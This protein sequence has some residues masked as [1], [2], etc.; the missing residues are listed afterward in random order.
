MN[1]YIFKKIECLKWLIQPLLFLLC[2]VSLEA[3]EEI[4]QCRDFAEAR[5]KAK[6]FSNLTSSSTNLETVPAKIL[7]SSKLQA[8]QIVGIKS[9]QGL[10]RTDYDPVKGPHFNAKSGGKKAAFCYPG[11]EQSHLSAV[12]NL[13]YGLKTTYGLGTH[14]STQST[15][16]GKTVLSRL[17]SMENINVFSRPSTSGQGSTRVYPTAGFASYQRANHKK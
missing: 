3:S 15:L 4:H 2:G 10:I 13:T 17:Q 7:G 6:A 16:Q 5:D 12:G 1:Q 9:T 14:R 8:G 11:N